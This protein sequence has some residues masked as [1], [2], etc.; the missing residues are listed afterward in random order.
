MGLGS[1]FLMINAS[2]WN[3]TRI[4]GSERE[5]Q[6]NT[7]IWPDVF[8]PGTRQRVYIESRAGDNGR[9]DG[10]EVNYRLGRGSRSNIQ[11]AYHD[12]K[13]ADPTITI[14]WQSLSTLNNPVGSVTQ[15]QWH[16]DNNSPFFISSRRTSTDQQRD[17]VTSNNP[18]SDWM[19]SIYNQTSCLTLREIVIPGSHDAGMSEINGARLGTAVNTVTQKLNVGD[20]LKYGSRYFDIR[21][22]I[23][24]GAWKT[25][26][27]SFVETF[28]LAWVGGNGQDIR[29][30]IDQINA[31]TA[32]NKELV[33]LNINSGLDTDH[34]RGE[35]DSG[36]SQAKWEEL[37]GGLINPTSGIKNRVTNIGNPR[38]VTTFRLDQ[39]IKDRAA[40]IMIVDSDTRDQKPVDISRFANQGIFTAKQFPIYNKYANDNSQKDMISDQLKKLQTQRINNTS[41]MFVLSWT[42]T[43][44]DIVSESIVEN[45][46]AANRALPELLW[47]ALSTKTYPNILYID[48]YP[49]NRDV[50]AL[51]MAINLWFTRTC[52]PE[53]VRT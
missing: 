38:D 29:S 34:F 45:G 50:A 11:V 23:S 7:W 49:S 17:L 39:L 28:N 52:P 32:K 26:H 47:P 19:H 43:Q 8:L 9:F 10:A 51:A 53:V 15:L 25:G 21:P 3:L 33:I 2:P 5:N 42:L 16:K 6:M 31:F 4:V 18:P 37:L 48:A 24:G 12:H 30:I 40:V 27:Y 13:D 1:W 35:R 44:K 22:V 41:E 20:Q 46:E 36:F 14:D